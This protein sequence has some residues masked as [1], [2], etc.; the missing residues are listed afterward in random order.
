MLLLTYITS[1]PLNAYQEYLF[2]IHMIAHMMLTMAVPVL[3]V[4]GAPITLLSRAV[5]KRIHPH[6]SSHLGRDAF[7][8]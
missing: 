7:H 1:G 2:S 3:L 4:P 6:S 8:P 5:A